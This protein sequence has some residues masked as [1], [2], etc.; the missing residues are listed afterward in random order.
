MIIDLAKDIH[1]CAISYGSTLVY[2]TV[3]VT[4]DPKLLIYFFKCCARDRQKV[5]SYWVGQSWSI[6]TSNQT[7]KPLSSQVIDGTMVKIYA[8]YDNECGYSY[9]LYMQA[10][11]EYMSELTDHSIVKLA[12]TSTDQTSTPPQMTTQHQKTWEGEMEKQENDEAPAV[13]GATKPSMCSHASDGP[14][15]SSSEQTTITVDVEED[16]PAFATGT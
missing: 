8:W 1:S 16:D 10:R 13:D 15:S 9:D 4:I 2:S 6:P 12:K 3:W 7:Q 14:L 11:C 5:I